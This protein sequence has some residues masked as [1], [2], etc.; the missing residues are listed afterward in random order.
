ML[1]VT[2]FVGALPGA[3]FARRQGNLWIRRTYFGAV[4]LLGLKTLLFDV[5]G[6]GSGLMKR[7]SMP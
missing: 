2:M 3:R 5:F 1:G 4:W 7:S 6:S